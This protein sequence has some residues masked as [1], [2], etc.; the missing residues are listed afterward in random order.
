MRS[1]KQQGY[2]MVLTLMII[3]I[4]VILVTQLFNRARVHRAFVH[5]ITTQEQARTVALSGIAIAQDLLFVAP[6]KQKPLRQAQGER[7][8]KQQKQQKKSNPEKEF[9]QKLLT[10]LNRW[11][12]FELQK[13]QDGIK[14]TLS[15]YISCED[16]KINLNQ[17]YDF[18]KKKFFGEGQP[19]G[20]Y[21]KIM[22]ELL[23]KIPPSSP[24]LFRSLG[25][26]LNQR[27]FKINDTTELLNNNEWAAKFADEVFTKF[28]PKG[29]RN[30]KPAIYLTD[31]FTIFTPS[32]T[33][34]PWVVSNSLSTLLE[35]RSLAQLESPERKEIIKN[36]T[37]EFTSTANWKTDWNKTVQKIY[38]KNFNSLPKSLHSMWST[39]FELTTFSV[40][41]RATVG[42]LSQSIFAILT[43][44]KTDTR[45]SY[46][47]EKIYW[48]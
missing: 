42:S 20:D 13:K 38:Q 9:L 27:G 12:I 39:E 1:D 15:L 37:K 22:T 14:A 48:I 18:E 45:V 33:V 16:G 47:I 4:S 10:F 31:L 8:D 21:K 23:Q 29:V 46:E 40:I 6:K 7:G 26:Y 43:K 2:I 34:N 11:Q 5:T 19:Q 41:V 17:I 36:G 30:E 24:Q 25:T 35:F 28:V 3:G 32:K 44:Q